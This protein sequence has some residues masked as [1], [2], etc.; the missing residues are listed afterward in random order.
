M[1][2]LPLQLHGHAPKA[3]GYSIGLHRTFG[4][5]V[6]VFGLPVP[7]LHRVVNAAGEQV[8]SG[9]RFGH[10]DKSGDV[11]DG[12]NVAFRAVERRHYPDYLGYARCGRACPRSVT[13]RKGASRK[14]DRPPGGSEGRRAGRLAGEEV[15]RK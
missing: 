15:P 7:V 13:G 3:G 1:I 4:H 12:Y 11:L 2:P 8:R 6:I 14:F 9:K 5:E 10:L